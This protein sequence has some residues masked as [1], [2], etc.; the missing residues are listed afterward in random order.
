M[1][2]CS[3]TRCNRWVSSDI[4]F[5][6]QEKIDKHLRFLPGLL[7][8]EFK[9]SKVTLNSVNDLPQQTDACSKSALEILETGVQYVHS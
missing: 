4:E 7:C 5:V 6:K 8:F 2:Y 1:I 9:I 3:W